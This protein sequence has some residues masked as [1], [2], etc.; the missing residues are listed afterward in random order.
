MKIEKNNLITLTKNTKYQTKLV[1][2]KGVAHHS[3]YC[4]EFGL[5]TMCAFT[6]SIDNNLSDNGGNLTVRYSLSMNSSFISL[7]EISVDVKKK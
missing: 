5:F 3:P 1:F 4:T 2:E 6:H 7:T